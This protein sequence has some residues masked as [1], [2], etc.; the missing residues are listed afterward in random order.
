VSLEFPT[1]DFIFPLSPSG[2]FS[3]TTAPQ[4]FAITGPSWISPSGLNLTHVLTNALNF[5]ATGMA[6]ATTAKLAIMADVPYGQLTV[7]FRWMWSALQPNGT[8][9][10]STWSTPVEG[11]HHGSSNLPTI[12]YPAEYVAFLSRPGG[13]KSVTIGT[14]YSA[15]LGGPV[16][17]NYYFLEMENSTGTV[18]NSQGTTMSGGV[19]TGNVTIPVLDYN[20]FL[21]PGNYLVHIHDACG[22]LLYNKQIHAAFAADA[23]ITFFLVPASCGP[24]TFN[25]TT[26]QNDTAGIY[27]PSIVPYSFTVP[28]CTGHSFEGWRGTGAVHVSSNDHLMISYNGT[29]TIIY[30]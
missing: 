7:E 14:N 29:F 21:V 26:Y 19:T 2:T 27:P 17:G 22:A 20:H 16:A 28:S 11:Y 4:T 6:R 25:G 13:G 15:T 18:V 1:V 8:S 3:K 10:N 9:A 23:N 30:K 24:M 12:F 5:S